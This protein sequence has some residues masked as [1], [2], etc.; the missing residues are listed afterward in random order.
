MVRPRVERAVVEIKPGSEALAEAAAASLRNFHPDIRLQLTPDR[1]I[2]ESETSSC[3]RL[4]TAWR[5]HFYTAK[6]YSNNSAARERLLT[7]L[8]Q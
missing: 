1:V 4:T 2:L 5:T 7:A 3:A 8:F 6:A